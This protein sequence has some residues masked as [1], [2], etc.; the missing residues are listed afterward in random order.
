[1]K[2]MHLCPPN[3]CRTQ[4]G[5]ATI[6]FALIATIFFTLLFGILEFGRMMYVFNSMQEIT[7]RGAREAVVR[8]IDQTSTVRTLALFG[9]T[10]LPAGA[11]LTAANIKID[12]LKKNG[13]VVTSFPFDPADN[14]S[15]CGDITRTDSCIYSVRVSIVNLNYIP[16]VSLFSFLNM[17]LPGSS[18]TMHA[19]SMGF[20]VS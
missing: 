10:S 3:P 1:M 20:T 9:G 17:A 16:M 2:K 19:E 14:L 8:W 18:S 4:R 7:R 5:V 11:E 15:A 13:A 12:Y 6:E